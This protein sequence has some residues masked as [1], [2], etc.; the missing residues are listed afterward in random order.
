MTRYQQRQFDEMYNALFPKMVNFAGRLCR[1]KDDAEDIA[2][3]AFIKAYAAYDKLDDGRKVDNWLMRIVYNTFLDLKRK[4]G[5]RVTEVS[6]V[7]EGSDLTL[8]D[9]PDSLP[10]AEQLLI[11][12]SLDPAIAKAIRQLDPKSRQLIQ[13]VFF[14]QRDQAELSLEYGVREGALRSRIHRVVSSLRK[15]LN[16]A[17]FAGA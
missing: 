1:N 8:D 4:R 15:D 5:R 16:R 14:E 7:V 9:C 13:Q 17:N 2:Q 10:S 11:A 12:K 6:A 3:E